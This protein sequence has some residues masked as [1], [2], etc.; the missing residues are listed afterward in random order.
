MTSPSDTVSQ[1]LERLLPTYARA[2]LTI[3][4]GEGSRVWDAGGR[5]YLDFGGGIAVVSLGH[6]HP[7]PLAAARE[8]LERLWHASNL[9]RTEPAE[10]LAARL[11][12]RFGGAQAFFCNSGAEAIEAA[13]KYARK[14]TG[15]PGVVALDGGFHGRTFGRAFRYRTAREARRLLAARPGGAVRA[16]ERRGRAPRSCDRRRRARA[17]RADPRRRRRPS[18]RPR[19]RCRG[20]GASGD[21]ALPRRDSDRRRPHRILLRVRGSRRAARS[22]DARQGP[23]KRASDRRPSRRRPSGGG[24]LAR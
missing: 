20:G 9:Y 10:A 12:D 17:A 5:E 2:D 24:V 11:S 7:A 23:R 15:R 16:S 1:G 22:R 6:C 21:T 18:A 3:V 14:A 8:Q 13:L 4:R 19:V